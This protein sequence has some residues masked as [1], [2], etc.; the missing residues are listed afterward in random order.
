MG[1]CSLSLPVVHWLWFSDEQF[2]YKSGKLANCNI[3]DSAEH[4]QEH[5]SILQWTVQ[6]RNHD[7]LDTWKLWLSADSTDL[8]G[9]ILKNKYRIWTF[10]WEWIHTSVIWIMRVMPHIIVWCVTFHRSCLVLQHKAVYYCVMQRWCVW[11]PL[12]TNS[13]VVHKHT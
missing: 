9:N 12:T 6:L 10:I 4:I 11:V 13:T 7:V 5:Q 2:I 8:N 3:L 1:V